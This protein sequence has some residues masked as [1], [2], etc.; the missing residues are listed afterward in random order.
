MTLVLIRHGHAEHNAS[1]ASR[2][3]EATSLSYTA[4]LTERGRKEVEITARFLKEWEEAHEPKPR[5]VIGYVSRLP[6]AIE[7]AGIIKAQFP[8]RQD[9]RLNEVDRGIWSQ[10]PH[11]QIEDIFPEEA[12][13]R[14]EVGWYWHRPYGG[15]S[16]SDAENRVAMWLEMLERA[17]FRDYPQVPGQ[18]TLVYAVIHGHWHQAFRMVVE[19]VSPSDIVGKDTIKVEA[20]ENASVLVYDRNPGDDWPWKLRQKFVPWAG[21]LPAPAPFDFSDI[22]PPTRTRSQTG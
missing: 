2:R 6:R 17:H 20:T 16:W 10:L 9:A 7:T 21:I 5:R 13:R 15:E 3:T 8:W 19:R 18:D 12:I 14:S 1:P 4:R 22:G 11:T